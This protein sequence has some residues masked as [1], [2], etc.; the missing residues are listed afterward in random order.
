MILSILIPLSAIT[1]ILN[2]SRQLH[3]QFLCIA[4]RVIIYS[5]P[6]FGKA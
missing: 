3:N 5:M 1:S 6:L 4:K 2:D